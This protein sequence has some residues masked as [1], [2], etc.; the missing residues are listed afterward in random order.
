LL[1]TATLA[2][3]RASELRGLPWRN[4]NLKAATLT[5]DQRADQDNLIGPC[6]SAA[7]YRTIPIPPTLVSVLREWKLRCPIGPLGLVFPAPEGGVAQHNNLLYP[8]QVECGL[9]RPAK[10]ASGKPKLDDE[11][12]PVLIGKYAFH[13]LRHAAASAWIKQR[14]D[15]KRLTTWIGHASVQ[16][17]L[18]TYGHLIIDED[19]DAA[20]VAAAQAELLG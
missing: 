8:L 2:G 15:L 10:L 14:L 4:V 6:K 5:I 19:G 13:A 20:L 7:A 12:A 17:T 11:G 9:G 16:Q 18:D 3:L 1:L